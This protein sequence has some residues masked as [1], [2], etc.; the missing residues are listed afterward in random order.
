V[1]DGPRPGRPGEADRCAA[2]REAVEQAD[3][4]CELVTHYAAENLGLKR[5][6]E[7]GLDW[8]FGHTEEAILLE[9]DCLPH[10]SFFRFCDELLERFRDEPR[11]LSISG[12]NFD[13][14]AGEAGPPD[15]RFSRYPHIWGWATWRRA[16]R[17][18][19]PAMARWPGLRDGGWLDGLLGERDTVRYWTYIFERTYK[20]GHTWDYA[21]LF[22]SWLAGGLSVVPS[23]NL[24][25][26]V[27]FRADA[28]NTHGEYRG[29][30]ADVPAVAMEFPLRHPS[31]L[32]RDVAADSFV[33]DVMFS[34][35]VQR[36]FERIRARRPEPSAR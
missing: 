14:S 24:V 5:R 25:T 33:E 35:N 31:S 17:H 4:G 19:D 16:W 7:S 1:G 34:G 32:H 13:A 26:N 22:A 8:A 27:G 28:T 10:P 30:F 2:A 11:V 18:Y 9:D 20:E 21:W 12:N 6:V 29:I 36:L 15:Y 3:W 23:R